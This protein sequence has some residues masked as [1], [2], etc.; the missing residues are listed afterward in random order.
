MIMIIRLLFLALLLQFGFAPSGAQAQATLPEFTVLEIDDLDLN[1]NRAGQLSPQERIKRVENSDMR[2]QLLLQNDI[3]MLNALSS[4]QEQVGELE[5][6][7]QSAGL[8]FDPPKPPRNICDQ[9]PSNSL[10][11]NAY[12]DLAPIK[13]V[14]NNIAAPTANANNA[15]VS[16]AKPMPQ[17]RAKN[18]EWDKISCIQDNCRAVIL[19]K[20]QNLKFS[21]EQGETLDNKLVISA[22]SPS[23]IT[24]REG[25]KNHELRAAL[26]N[27][28]VS[29]SNNSGL[30]QDVSV[31]DQLST[32]PVSALEA[33]DPVEPIV[34]DDGSGDRDL[35]PPLGPTGLF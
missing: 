30:P 5:R 10:C 18:Y 23:G 1:T 4:W 29:S 31:T 22:I 8:P 19:D 34:L 12:E 14:A 21:V 24:V 27:N 25:G 6:T 17:I 9:V 32:L 35:A 16:Q 28:N 13:T 15:P 33:I 7:Y 3:T 2:D 26:P 20:A 11:A